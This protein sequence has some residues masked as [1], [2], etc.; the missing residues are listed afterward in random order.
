M[1]KSMLGGQ[2]ST[3]TRDVLMTGDNPLASAQPVT[4]TVSMSA[5]RGRGGRN[6]GG[7]P[8]RL[9]GGR[10]GQV[11]GFGRS[12]S[13]QGLPQV[14]GLALGAPEFQRR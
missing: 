8:P 13:L 12:V 11:P 7:L 2:V 1:I 14:V 4:D 5:G 10:A 3:E 6:P 9:G